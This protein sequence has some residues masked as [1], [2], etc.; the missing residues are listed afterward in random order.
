[1]I[2]DNLTLDVLRSTT[3]TH[4]ELCVMV[5]LTTETHKSP[6]LS[7]VSGELMLVFT[8]FKVFHDMT[9]RQQDVER[10]TAATDQRT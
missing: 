8:L 2:T 1:V 6:A 5:G 7:S 10:C 9:Q 4:G 3:T